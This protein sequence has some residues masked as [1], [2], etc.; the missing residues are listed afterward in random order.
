[1]TIE[2]IV[3][4]CAREG[5]GAIAVIGGIYM[6]VYLVKNILLSQ[7]KELSS[8]AQSFSGFMSFVRKEHEAQLKNQEA[9]LRNHEEIFKQNREI[10]EILKSINNRTEKCNR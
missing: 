9:Q 4:M 7:T 5:I 3:R 8:L 2:E 1:M 10:T 6:L